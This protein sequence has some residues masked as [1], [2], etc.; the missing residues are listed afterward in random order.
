MTASRKCCPGIACAALLWASTPAGAAVPEESLL[1]ALL[2]EFREPASE[3][4]WQ[5]SHLANVDRVLSLHREELAGFSVAAGGAPLATSA[6]GGVLRIVLETRQRGPATASVVLDPARSTSLERLKP[7]RRVDI[8]LV[9]TGGATRPLFCGR[10]ASVVADSATGQLQ[11]EAFV[12]RVGPELG[13]S[14]T[15]RD[16]RTVDILAQVANGVGLSLQ[17]P[18]GFAS[19]V[20]PTLA[21]HRLADWPFM[22]D[23]ARRDAMELVLTAGG[24]LP[25]SYGAFRPPPAPAVVQRQWQELTWIDIAARIAQA[26][27]RTLDAGPY[28]AGPL[29]RIA[30]TQAEPNDDFL[31]DLARR[32][33]ASA[34]YAAGR[35]LLRADQAW[36]PDPARRTEPAILTTARQLATQVA[37][38]YGLPL[39]VGAIQDRQ[40]QVVQRDETDAELLLRVLGDAGLRLSDRDGGLV[41]EQAS[42]PGDVT[43]LLLQRIVVAGSASTQRSFQRVFADPRRQLLDPERLPLTEVRLDLGT[44]LQPTRL[45]I[46]APGESTTV[47]REFESALV[48]LGPA[49]AGSPYR[50]FLLD[51]A[52]TYR[53]TLLHLYRTRR[54]GAS[55]LAAI[56]P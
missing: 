56:Q 31:F 23:L 35:V 50:R 21:R 48:R 38:R 25:L 3:C 11:F 42:V 33:Q 39:R 53:P 19:P 47:A 28:A 14:V 1:D 36:R 2:P 40:V 43:D 18:G 13:R 5:A 6:T 24:T 4:A 55:Q 51:L 49:A 8:R 9:H 41:L 54:D 15:Y 52:R 32:H 44:M 17:V 16:L 30:V 26:G 7:G 29:P 20:L 12:P 10:V 22:L 45:R 34:Y 37:S 46:T 27:G